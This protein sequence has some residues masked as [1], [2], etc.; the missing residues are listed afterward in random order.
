VKTG[1]W[2]KV[3]EKR[4]VKLVGENAWVIIGGWNQTGE[5]QWVFVH[6]Y[7]RVLVK[8]VGENWWVK[9][10][11]RCL[12]FFCLWTSLLLVLPQKGEN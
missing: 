9:I 11:S 1:G 10:G 4:W 7:E 6:L 8:V 2:K 3:G 5:F 12:Y